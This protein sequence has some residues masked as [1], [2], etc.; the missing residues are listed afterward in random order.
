MGSLGDNGSGRGREKSGSLTQAG[1]T[2]RGVTS[3]GAGRVSGHFFF[4]V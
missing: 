4:K 1:E 2:G 3:V